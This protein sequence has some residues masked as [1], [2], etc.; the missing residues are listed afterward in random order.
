VLRRGSRGVLE[1]E[2][3]LHIPNPKALFFP[4]IACIAFSPAC[5]PVGSYVPISAIVA[6]A[7]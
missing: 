6:R 5:V 3:V 7:S 1:I 2:I 4:K